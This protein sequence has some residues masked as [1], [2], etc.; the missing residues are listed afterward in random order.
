MGRDSN[1]A[2]TH[3]HWKKPWFLKHISMELG[4]PLKHIFI[5][6]LDESCILIIFI[7]LDI[8]SFFPA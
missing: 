1:L 2:G 7:L 6:E 5:E 4:K 8:V 3:A